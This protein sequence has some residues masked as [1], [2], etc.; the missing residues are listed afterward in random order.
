MQEITSVEVVSGFTVRL[1]FRDGSVREVD[2][3]P[4]L[5]GP[6]FS[7]LRA[8]P[9]LFAQIFVDREVGTI[10]WPNGADMDADVLHGDE[11]PSWATRTP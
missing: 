4:L 6:M 8:D 7:E 10:A 3:E 1:T 5:R 11:V 9:D 2:L